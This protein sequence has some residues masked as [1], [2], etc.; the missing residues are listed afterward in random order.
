MPIQPHV[1]FFERL[2]IGAYQ[3][4]PQGQQVRANDALVKLNGYSSEHEMLADLANQNLNLGWYVQPDRR[5]AFKQQMDQHGRVTNFVSEVHRQKTRERIWVRETAYGLRDDQGRVVLYEGT[6]EDITESHA[7]AQA[8]AEAETRWRLALD[9]A[10]EGVWDLDIPSGVEHCSDQLKRMLGFEAGELLATSQ[11]L[12]QRIHPDDLAHMDRASEAH[13]KG[14]TPTYRSE[15]RIMCKDG[16][17]KWVLSRGMVVSWDALGRPLRMTGTHTDISA[18]KTAEALLWQQ[19]NLD[20]LTGLPNR[21]M[22][23]QQLEAASAR[24]AQA[25]SWL[26]VVFIDLDQFKAV[27]DIWGHGVGDQLLVQVAR[28]IEQCLRPGD[29]VA[30]MG[31]DEFTLLINGGYSGSTDCRTALQPLLDELLGALAAQFE[32]GSHDVFVS[33]SMGVACFPEHATQ[34]EDLLKHADLALYSAK[35][36]GRNRYRFFNQDMQDAAQWR[37]RLDG[38]LRTALVAGQ[39]EVVYQPMVELATDRVFK[40]EALLRWQHP[41]LG[42]VSP[43]QFIPVAEASGLIVPIG[44]WVFEQALAQVTAWRQRLGDTFQISVNK[45]PVQCQHHVA[46]QSSWAQK[47]KAQG[48]PVNCI[49]ME[50]TEGLLLDTS[51]EMTEH[52]SALRDDGMDVSLDDF[53]TGYS[54][55]SYLQ[56]LDIDYLKIDQSFVRNLSAESTDLALCKAIIAMANALGMKVVAEGVETEQQRDL[57]RQAGCHFGQ[58]YLFARPMSPVAF[59]SWAAMAHTGSA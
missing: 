32:L 1:S 16:S 5:E 26:G 21:H 49:A 38:D 44:E 45:S 42:W 19:A 3:T 47:L 39:F 2:P 10:G 53:G 31:G 15:H 50:I 13:Y 22:L 30:R 14:L 34:I 48:L 59:E 12:L 56:K 9:A 18:Q 11:L 25:G 37:A 57:L 40:A 23:R 27:N 51:Q 35:A 29:T 54:S 55:L 8:L 20:A 58:G 4:T 33:A 43:A 28:R 24:M 6:V 36:A 46:Q 52:L 17:W 7:T 41:L